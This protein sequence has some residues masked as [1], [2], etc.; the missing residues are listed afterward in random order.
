ME[1]NG[2]A[3]DGRENSGANL[4]DFVLGYSRGRCSGHQSTSVCSGLGP[5]DTAAEQKRVAHE[6]GPG[7]RDKME[8]QVRVS[9]SAVGHPPMSKWEG[10]DLDTAPRKE[11]RQSAL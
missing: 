10:K 2:P 8:T 1:E 9:L 5:C 4:Q 11:M 7:E 6:D 3:H